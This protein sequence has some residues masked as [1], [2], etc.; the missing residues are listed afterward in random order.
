MILDKKSDDT[1][2]SMTYT[3]VTTASTD[4]SKRFVGDINNSNP[5]KLTRISSM[6]HQLT[7]KANEI[8]SSFPTFFC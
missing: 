5:I 2:E 3:D 6:T 1:K 7:T 4:E 8:Q